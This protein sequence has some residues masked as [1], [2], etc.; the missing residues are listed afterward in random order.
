LCSP[1]LFLCTKKNLQAFYD[2]YSFQLQIYYSALN[3]LS[4]SFFF[5]LFPL[6]F[7][8]VIPSVSS[9]HISSF[10]LLLSLY[11]SFL[12]LLVPNISVH[13]HVKS[14]YS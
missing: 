11:I 8:S 7:T 5:L 13:I 2:P 9:L 6:T 3:D 1:V 4:V 12:S 14:I 10:S